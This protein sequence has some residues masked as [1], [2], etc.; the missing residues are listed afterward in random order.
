MFLV[1]TPS[2][3][4]LEYVHPLLPGELY[5]KSFIAV[6]PDI[7]WMV[8]GEWGTMSHLQIYP[9]PLLNHES[10]SHGGSLRL[11]GYI[12]LSHKVNDVQGCDFVTPV[13][14]ICASDD[15]SRTL[16]PNEKPLVE[17]D[18]SKSL[19]G[20]STKGH[21]ADLGSIPQK[22]SCSGTFEAEGVDYDV[23]TRILRVEVI[24]PGSCILRTTIY[25]YRQRS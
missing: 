25:K 17:I 4:S 8:V 18:L 5:N 19:H 15:D 9:T 23:A 10:P 22:S 12:E 24:Q 21:V 1:T 2:G 16:F 7:Q 13:R 14:L 6:S 11:T 3:K 20:V